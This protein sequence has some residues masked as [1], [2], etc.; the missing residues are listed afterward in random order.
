MKCGARVSR[1][2]PSTRIGC[3]NNV[4]SIDTKVSNFMRVSG[5]GED[6][7]SYGSL[8]ER[9]RFFYEFEPQ[10]HKRLAILLVT[11][12]VGA[13]LLVKLATPTAVPARLV[14]MSF[15][16]FTNTPAGPRALLAIRYHPRWSG[17]AW[18][19][20]ETSRWVDGAWQPWQTNH[21]ANLSLVAV[22]KPPGRGRDGE[23]LDCLMA[24]PVAN[25]NDAWRFV[26]L[27]EEGP[28]LPP[29]IVRKTREFFYRLRYGGPAPP[30]PVAQ[31]YYVTNETTKVN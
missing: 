1:V 25:T 2:K 4:K 13:L 18:W 6:T 5:G 16:Q 19:D 31:R 29:A 11:L 22:N 7:A 28:P 24:L 15:H 17:S 8:R 26:M 3:I 12:A 27:V 21:N 9:L 30:P 14:R 20:A 10:M 23:T